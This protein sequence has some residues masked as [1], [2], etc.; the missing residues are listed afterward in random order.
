MDDAAL[1]ILVALSAAG[2]STSG[3]WG[4]G[5]GTIHGCKGSKTGRKGWKKEK[6]KGDASDERSGDG[7]VKVAC[8]GWLLAGLL[9]VDVDL[10]PKRTVLA[11]RNCYITYIR[12]SRQTS[13]EP[14]IITLITPSTVSTCGDYA[15]KRFIYY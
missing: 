8:S 6:R 1:F 9:G 10:A 15:K 2:V 13:A 5:T 12:P 3:C 7:G 14:S 4:T 11:W